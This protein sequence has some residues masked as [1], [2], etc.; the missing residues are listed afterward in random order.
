MHTR[1]GNFR[2]GVAALEHDVA[3]QIAPIIRTGG[4]LVGNER[5]KAAGIVVH[6]RGPDRVRPRA[7]GNGQ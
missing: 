6:V 7:T 1:E 2:Y 3:M 5:G 4:V